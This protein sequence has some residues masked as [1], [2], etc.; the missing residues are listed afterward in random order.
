MLDSEDASFRYSSLMPM[1][2]VDAANALGI[3]DWLVLATYFAGVI[4]LGI[5]FASRQKSSNRYFLGVRNLPGWAIGLSMFATIISSWAFLALPGKA[6]AADLQYLM[7]IATLPLSTV[8]ATRLLIP[9]FRSRIRL[10]AY[11]YLESRF[12]LP[13]RAY[14]NLAFL[15]V[16]FGKMGAILYLLCLAVSGMTG[17]NLYLLIVLVGLAT[18]VYTYVGGIEAVVWTDVLQGLLLIGSAIF[19]FVYLLLAAPGGASAIVATASEAGKLKLATTAWTWEGVSVWVL[20]FF[21]L[22][23][24]FQKYATDQTVVQRYL[25]AK[26][27]RQT[28]RALWLSSLLIMLVWVLFMAIG[29]L[30]WAFYELQPG[31]LPEAVKSRPDAVF[32]Y[33]IGHQLPTGVSGLILSGLLAATMST[34]ASDLNSLGAVLFEDYYSKLVRQASERSRLDFSR[35][36]VLI[37]GVL[38]I[39]LG[40]WMTSIHSMADA[41]FEF[42]SV[43]SGGVLGLY[44]LGIFTR[45]ASPRG[46]YLALT[47]GVAFLAWAYMNPAIGETWLDFLPRFPFNSLWLGLLGNVLVFVVG[48]AASLILTPGYRWRPPVSGKEEI[49]SEEVRGERHVL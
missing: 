44:L 26:S 47:L 7:A 29:A 38:V 48:L 41:A 46:A 18:V 40:L 21:G 11:E 19:S 17:W 35:A 25:L 5:H 20:L 12:G 3:L 28:V 6:F 33:F 37:S 4:R 8:I 32:P 9:L 39:L 13:A 22:N 42:V 34:L 14:G 10:S 36:S 43:V 15:V 1:T 45:R 49:S 23:Y 24:Y 30:L 27:S 31:L 2:T 16:H